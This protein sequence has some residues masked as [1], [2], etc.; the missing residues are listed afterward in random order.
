MLASTVPFLYCFCFAVVSVMCLAYER[1]ELEGVFHVLE[2]DNRWLCL[3][4]D[5]GFGV[6]LVSR[7]V[8]LRRRVLG[9]V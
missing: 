7:S 2:T 4:R 1:S 6:E 9:C 3:F 5:G 8:C